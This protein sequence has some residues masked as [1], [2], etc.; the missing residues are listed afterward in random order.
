MKHMQRFRK[1]L[2]LGVRLEWLKKIHLMHTIL[3]LIRLNED[4]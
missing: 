4:F 2:N 1:I 3:D